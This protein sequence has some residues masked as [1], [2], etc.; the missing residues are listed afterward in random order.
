MSLYSSLNIFFEGIK[1]P[2]VN[3]RY[4]L[5]RGFS[6]FAYLNSTF[7]LNKLIRWVPLN[8]VKLNTSNRKEKVVASLTSYPGR[9]N[10]VYYAI[11]SIMLQTYSPDRVVLW[12]AEEQFPD[13]QLPER[14]KCL[15]EKGLEIRYCDDLRSHKKYFYMLQEQ[16]PNE[17]VITFDDDII[18]NVKSIERAVKKHQ[19]F[20]KAIV[21]NQAKILRCDKNGKII[22][23][24]EWEMNT[25]EKIPSFALSPL[26][27]SGCLYPY[28]AMSECT[29]DWDIIKE[30]A[31]TA[32]DIW[33]NFLSKKSGTQIVEVD[34]PVKRFSVVSNSQK[35][36]LAQ[37]NSLQR[38]NDIIVENLSI[39][40]PEVLK[41]IQLATV[42]HK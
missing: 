14:L 3:R 26:T 33:I 10:E 28:G 22:P 8:K 38:G 23:Y 15:V 27:G 7:W 11:K 9:I 34:K 24:H 17:L 13:K 39:L 41:M 25:D 4:K 40:F 16:Q 2:K 18:Y 35:T 12:L 30:N 32:D 20:P 36:H 31:L 5:M 29:F 1:D 42:S 19:A 21:V 6:Y 37:I